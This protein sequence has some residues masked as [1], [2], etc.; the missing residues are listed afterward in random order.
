M[1]SISS[2][3]SAARHGQHEHGAERVREYAADPRSDGD[4]HPRG[5]RHAGTRSVRDRSPAARQAHDRDRPHQAARHVPDLPRHRV[6]PAGDVRGDDLHA[7]PAAA[8]LHLVRVR[9]FAAPVPDGGAGGAARRAC[10]GRPGG[11]SLSRTRQAHAE[12]RRAGRE[13]REDRRIAWERRRDAGR[14]AA[15]TGAR[16]CTRRRL[17]RSPCDASDAIGRCIAGGA[18]GLCRGA[19]PPRRTIRTAPSA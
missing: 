15:D 7:Q 1:C 12:Q 5:R 13:G 19:L 11:Q 16:A 9:D 4:R 14:R 8:R 2:P 3:T 17:S 10:A 18:R 6:G